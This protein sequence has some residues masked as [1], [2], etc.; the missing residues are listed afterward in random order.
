MAKLRGIS[1]LP[2]RMALEADDPAMGRA[3]QAFDQPILYGV[4]AGQQAGRALGF[5][6]ALMMQAV[7][8]EKAGA[9]HDGGGLGSRRQENR[10]FDRLPAAI[11]FFRLM[12]RQIL[13]Q[14]PAKGHIEQLHPP[15][16]RQH[17]QIPAQGIVQ[18]GQFQ[19]IQGA[20]QVQ[21]GRR[22][23]FGPIP[24]RVNIRAAGQQQAANAGQHSGRRPGRRRGQQAD[25]RPQIRHYA[26]IAAG[27][28]R[29]HR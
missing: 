22:V 18:Q 4:G 8:P 25:F 2:L 12:P 6:Q 1:P 3:F 24:G 11:G 14:L 28:I 7:D 26:G 21:V 19:G 9:A 5:P 29:I 16:D 15:A 23:R 20:A 17:R 27:V 13:N 10:M